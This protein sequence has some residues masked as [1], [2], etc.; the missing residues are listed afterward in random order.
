MTGLAAASM[1]LDERGVIQA[2]KKADIIVFDPAH[3]KDKS[4]FVDPYQY[5]EGIRH[6]WI[7]GVPVIEQGRRTVHKPGK[8]LRRSG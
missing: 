8:V 2:G 7:N 1:G 6:V 5:A 3:F 4:T